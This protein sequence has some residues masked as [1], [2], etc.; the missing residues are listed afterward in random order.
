[1]A[2]SRNAVNKEVSGAVAENR[3][4]R[5]RMRR[6]E[7]WEWESMKVESANAEGAFHSD[8]GS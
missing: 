4:R 1:M 5:L 7:W 6:R 3:R 2:C 8:E